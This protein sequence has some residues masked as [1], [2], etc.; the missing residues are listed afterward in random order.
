M[1]SCLWKEGR[2]GV[3]GRKER[4]IQRTAFGMVYFNKS[5]TVHLAGDVRTVKL[6]EEPLVR[7]SQRWQDGK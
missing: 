5:H 7:V 6:F 2:E 4:K 1:V 3:V